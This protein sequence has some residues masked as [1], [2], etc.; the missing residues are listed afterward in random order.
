MPANDALPQPY[1]S[2]L[3]K[4]KVVILTKGNE[5]VLILGLEIAAAPTMF[6]L[7]PLLISRKFRRRRSCSFKPI[8]GHVSQMME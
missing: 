1:R 2:K 3:S 6:A 7:E 4:K 5:E 8:E